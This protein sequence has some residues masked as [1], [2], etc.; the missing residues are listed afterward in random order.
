[1]N[2]LANCLSLQYSAISA[3]FLTNRH[4]LLAPA[5]QMS[6][7]IKLDGNSIRLSLLNRLELIFF[8]YRIKL[9]AALL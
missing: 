5:L 8:V 7:Q 2:V 6:R 1:M 9:F 3:S 4:A